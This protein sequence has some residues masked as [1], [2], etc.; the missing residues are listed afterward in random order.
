MAKT[1]NLARTVTMQDVAAIV[2]G[3]VE[4]A[5]E[6]YRTQVALHEIEAKR[7][8]VLEEIHSRHEQYR[9]VF[10]HIF[11]ERRLTIG[12]LFDVL[13]EGMAAKDQA[14]VSGALCGLSQIVATSPFSDLKQ[15]A[16][17]LEGHDRLD[18]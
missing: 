15:L 10:E 4:L 3:L 7:A 17:V 16:G 18:I 1:V 2:T 13:D 11:G 8:V 9:R 6:H 12:K 5:R 14:V